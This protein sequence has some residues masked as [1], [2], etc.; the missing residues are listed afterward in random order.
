MKQELKLE[1]PGEV[2]AYLLQENEG[3]LAKVNNMM[4]KCQKGL[5]CQ[6]IH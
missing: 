2:F 4:V 6:K 3:S 5:K 1:K